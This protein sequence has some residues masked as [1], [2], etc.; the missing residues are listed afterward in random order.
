[1]YNMSYQ[2]ILVGLT[3]L[4]S[5]RDPLRK[6]AN[7]AISSGVSLVN[8]TIGALSSPPQEQQENADAKHH[9]DLAMSD[10]GDVVIVDD[11]K[12]QPAAA[13][14]NRN[15]Q[16]AGDGKVIDDAKRQNPPE[17]PAADADRRVQGE[18]RLAFF[19]PEQKP[20][21]PKAPERAAVTLLMFSGKLKLN[22]SNKMAKSLNE[23]SVKV[24]VDLLLK[25]DERDQLYL[26]IPIDK[27]TAIKSIGTK[28]PTSPL[29]KAKL[30]D[31]L[32]KLDGQQVLITCQPCSFEFYKRF[33]NDKELTLIEPSIAAAHKLF[34]RFQQNLNQL[35]EELAAPA[36]QNGFGRN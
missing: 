30:E 3:F 35:I 25:V 11:A 29:N 18:L 27:I 9:R 26:K 16:G 28:K 2:D 31:D 33:G 17:V 14:A 22:H 6:A 1:M 4:Y 8:K 32:P 5:A 12:P 7:L 21:G 20:A 10:D 23:R 24:F 34:Q 13:D 19:Q 36:A 15:P